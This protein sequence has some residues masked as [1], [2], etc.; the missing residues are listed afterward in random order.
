MDFEVTTLLRRW[1][2]GDPAARDRLVALIGSELRILAASYLRGERSGHTLQP[3][4]LVNELYLRLVDRRQVEWQDRRHF[5][6]F[7]ATTMR[8]ILVDYARQRRAD[9]RGRGDSAVTLQDHAALTSQREVDLL[10]LDRALSELEAE[11]PRSSRVVELRFFGGLTIEEAA[12]VLGLGAAT[13]KRDLRA[14]KAFLLHRLKASP[15]AAER[16]VQ[17]APEDGP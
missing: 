14:A 10:D 17:G 9:K 2:G 1:N 6:A 12:E 15:A 16:G 8:R 13:V 11:D 7:A 4:A 3:T 5:F